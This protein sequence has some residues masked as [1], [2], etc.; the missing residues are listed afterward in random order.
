MEFIHVVT[1][2]KDYI[3]HL[4]NVPP[5]PLST[6]TCC[7]LVISVSPLSSDGWTTVRGGGCH[8]CGDSPWGLR[9][10]ACHPGTDHANIIW[11]P[12]RCCR[13]EDFIYCGGNVAQLVECQ[14]GR[15]LRQVRFHG[16]ARDFSLKVNSQCRLSFNVHTPPCATA[17]INI[18]A[19]I[20]DPVV[21]VR[22]WWI[23]E[24]LKHLACTEGLVAWFCRSW[25]SLGKIPNGQY[26]C[27]S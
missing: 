7:V 4:S 1:V 2:F 15:L 5:W 8:P 12:P 6:I 11:V 19:H 20:K 3:D 18:C 24:A 16:A 21:H 26:R 23:M 27:K 9:W 17:R 13:G 14:T 22:V 25:L 10:P